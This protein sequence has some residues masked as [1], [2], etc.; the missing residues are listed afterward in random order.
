MANESS[1]PQYRPSLLAAVL[2]GLARFLTRIL[3]RI[4]V[5][6]H[7][8]VPAVGGALLVCNHVSFVD[9]LLV[10]TACRDRKSVV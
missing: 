10:G 4:R 5:L 6:G 2:R 1:T 3:Y 9:A 8:N 7:D